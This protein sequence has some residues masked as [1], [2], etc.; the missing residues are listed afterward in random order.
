M[1][2]FAQLRSSEVNARRWRCGLNDRQPATRIGF[3]ER[4]DFQAILR[5]QPF[6]PI[7]VCLTDGRTVVVRHPDQV[8]LTR[9]KAVFGLVHVQDHRKRLMTTQSE[10]R[11]VTDTLTVDLLHVVSAE[12]ANGTKRTKPKRRKKRP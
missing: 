6:E 12:R 4:D 9:R 7:E 10:D 5:E 3:M 1:V 2:E 11:R 8:M